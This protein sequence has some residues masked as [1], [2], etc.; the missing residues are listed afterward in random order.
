MSL[1]SLLPQDSWLL[2]PPWVPLSTVVPHDL[3]LTRLLQLAAWLMYLAASLRLLMAQLLLLAAQLLLM[4][5]LLQALLLVHLLARHSLP[6]W[7]LHA[8]E[9]R[10]R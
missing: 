6:A 1:P 2:L 4:K 9:Q 3:L 10:R 7:P 8:A 5:A